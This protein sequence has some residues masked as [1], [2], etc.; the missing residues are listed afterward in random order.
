MKI[1]YTKEFQI[2]KP[3]KIEEIQSHPNTEGLDF[4]TFFDKY[5][6]EQLE[7][8]EQIRKSCIKKSKY[9]TIITVII[10]LLTL[11]IPGNAR[12]HILFFSAFI[13]IGAAVITRGSY[14]YEIKSRIM[15]VLLSYLGD[16]YPCYGKS[17]YTW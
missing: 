5:I 16:F 9:I 1:T 3:H 10:C 17:L 6:K 12:W 15:N 13:G 7:P 2:G 8:I 4:D 14:K 11:L